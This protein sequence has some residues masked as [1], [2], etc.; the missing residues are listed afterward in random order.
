MSHTVIHRLFLLCFLFLSLITLNQ[1]QTNRFGGG[2]AVGFNAAQLDGDAA[3][4][5]HKIGL[6]VGL[7]GFATLNGDGRMRI[8]VGLL[9]SK[10]GMR[11]TE[12][13]RGPLRSMTLDYIEIPV[14]FS[15]LDW[16]YKPK[17]GGQ[18][19]YKVHFTGGLSYGNL[20][21]L[22]RTELVTHPQ[23]AVDQFERNDYAW[24][25]GLG[26]YINRHW[27][28]SWRYTRSINFL[29]HPKNHSSDPVL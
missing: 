15:Y 25:A 29:F 28:F 19:Y 8:N 9:W 17:D 11:S 20:F 2:L 5:Y 6:G 27:G 3:A 7:N 13:D 24:T 12:N 4:G 22:R 14:T 1:A 21:N 18:A 10:R 26:Y 16:L 23:A